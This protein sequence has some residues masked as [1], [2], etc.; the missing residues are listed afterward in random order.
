[1]HRCE[2]LKEYG[3]AN[4]K[5]K[6]GDILKSILDG[7][8]YIIKKVVENMVMLEHKMEKNKF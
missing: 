3:R 2:G 4:M 8:N 1:L 5:P 6:S 7:E